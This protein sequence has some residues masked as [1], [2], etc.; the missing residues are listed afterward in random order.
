MP[1]NSDSLSARQKRRSLLAF[2]ASKATDS[3]P[4]NGFSIVLPIFRSIAS[5]NIGE[6]VNK[7]KVSS[8]L[9]EKFGLSVGPDL[10]NYWLPELVSAKVITKTIDLTDGTSVYHWAEV[11]NLVAYDVATFDSN[12]DDLVSAYRDFAGS[13]ADLFTVNT[14]DDKTI[15]IIF[16]GVINQ[17]FDIGED[18]IIEKTDE[19]YY[20][21]R[22]VQFLKEN[23]RNRLLEFLS[24]IRLCSIIVDLI[25]HLWTP[26]PTQPDL[27]R[28]R[29]YLDAPIVMDALGLNGKERKSR[30]LKILDL[31][32]QL[33]ARVYLSDFYIREIYENI[34]GFLHAPDKDRHGRMWEAWRK[35]EVTENVIRLTQVKLNELIENIGIYIETD[36][37]TLTK[38]SPLTETYFSHLLTRLSSSYH[39]EKACKRDIESFSLVLSRRTSTRPKKLENALAIFVTSNPI[40]WMQANRFATERLGYKFGD[41]PCVIQLRTLAGMMAGYFGI[42]KSREISVQ[43]LLASASSAVA[44]DPKVFER[45][46]QAIRKIRPDE[47]DDLIPLLRTDFSRIVLDGSAGRPQNITDDKAEQIVEKLHKQFSDDAD[48]RATERF[49]SSS[50]RVANER[51]VARAS[52]EA[53]TIS[54]VKERRR[55]LAKLTPLIRK[56]LV[57]Q[58]KAERETHIAL[59][60]LILAVCALVAIPF[61]LPDTSSLSL[62]FKLVLAGGA[63][64]GVLVG[65]INRKVVKNFWTGIRTHTA[66]TQLKQAT[67][68]IGLVTTVNNPDELLATWRTE[69]ERIFATLPSRLNK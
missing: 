61:V 50:R 63:V 64:A 62:T 25:F 28:L 45:L 48:K 13:N 68:I 58:A 52:L 43:E 38:R 69:R 23:D 51:D 42:E 33:K 47:A 16:N 57:R 2:A 37:K 46:E 6:I 55:Q 3:S 26:S 21:G 5:D 29:F 7:E 66:K 18:I 4:G 40:I 54:K 41:V 44:A 9:S 59:L 67:E 56:V 22:F 39:N 34:D 12:L 24:Y 53:L 36:T 20:F 32:K 27:T 19:D 15:D 17:L 31:L 49:K 30:S 65:F 14:D 8:T 11:P 10:I 60:I 1:D 35:A